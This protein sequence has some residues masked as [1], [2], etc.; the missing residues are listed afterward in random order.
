MVVGLV[1]TY[2]LVLLLFVLIKTIGEK[3]ISKNIKKY[4]IL[5]ICCCFVMVLSDGAGISVQGKTFPGAV[6]LNYIS[7]TIYFIYA[8]ITCYFAFLVIDALSGKTILK[9]KKIRLCFSLPVFLYAIII[10]ISIKTGWVFSIDERTNRYVRGPVNF[11]QFLFCYSYILA[12]LILSFYKY[13]KGNVD[14][15]RDIYFANVL[16]CLIPTL[17]G[18]IQFVI[19]SNGGL[20]LPIISCGLTFSTII[21]FVEMVQNQVS[22]DSLTGLASRKAFYKYLYANES[23]DTKLYVFMIDI[24]K[25]KYINDNF[26][27]LEGDHALILFAQSLKTYTRKKKGLAARLGGDEFAIA[28]EL[29]NDDAVEYLNGLYLEIDKINKENDIKYEI[30]ASI[31]YAQMTEDES[32]NNLIQRADAEMYNK[33]TDN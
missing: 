21:V 10:L 22:L 23:N 25:F 17:G 27:H 14:P 29:L 6:V 15:N 31:G 7:Q 12:A 5:C 19:S 28:V 1:I 4:F 16:F 11:F 30:S 2:C 18:V 33:K 8:S 26:G 32:I 24:N 9:T 13:S 3:S 20:D